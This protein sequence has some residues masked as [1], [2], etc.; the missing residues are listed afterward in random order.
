VTYFKG[1]YPEG[2]RHKS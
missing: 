2:N 1:L